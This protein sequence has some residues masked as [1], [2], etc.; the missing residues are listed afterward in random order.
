MH[1]LVVAE[2]EDLFRKELEAATDWERRGFILVGAA[3]DGAEA[4]ELVRARSPELV[5]TDV[6]MPRLD[7]LGLL[8]AIAAELPEDERPLVVMLS[9]HSDF[10]YAREALR[11]GAFDYLLKPL[12]DAEL[13][14]SLAR[15]RETL[16]A[17]SRRLALASAPGAPALA[18]FSEY[19]PSGPR[20]AADLRVERAVS[21]IASGYVRDLSVDE[22][23]A[24]MGL[25]G[26]R[27]ARLF[28]AKTGLTFSEY[29][30]RHRMKR[31]AELLMDPSLR[32]G[33]V[34]D[35]VGYRDQRHFASLFRRFVGLT[36]TRFR[37][38]RFDSREE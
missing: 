23:A 16:A 6:R 5:V 26:S 17:R 21:A 9:A 15:A 31:A 36:P 20:D 34:A 11:L 38:G 32:V 28:K 4:L 22:V 13:D 1:R 25:S 27:L 19:A 12:D 14:A 29:L 37:E 3:A 33:E 24:S 10:A 35:L 8:A 30:V 7:G 18:F 2:D